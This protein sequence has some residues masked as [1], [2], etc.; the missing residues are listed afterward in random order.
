MG[1]VCVS[2]LY[3]VSQFIYTHPSVHNIVG[4]DSV[5]KTVVFAWWGEER[6]KVR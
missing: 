6:G 2:R 1:L 3:H 4:F 5:V